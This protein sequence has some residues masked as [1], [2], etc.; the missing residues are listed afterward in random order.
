MMGLQAGN[1]PIITNLGLSTS[2]SCL[3]LSF[4]VHTSSKL[5]LQP[6]RCLALL[7]LCLWNQPRLLSEVSFSRDILPILSD[8]CFQCHG[9]DQANR[10]GNLRLDQFESAVEGGKGVGVIVPG[11]PARSLLVERIHALDA[12][13][14]MPPPEINKPLCL[15]KKQ[16]L[17]K[18]IHQGAPWGQHWSFVP[19]KRP[20]LDATQGHPIDVFIDQKLREKGMS[21]SPS[22]SDS[23]Q[24]RRLSLDL[25]GLP[26]S[27]ALLESFKD[28]SIPD[29]WERQVERLLESPHYDVV[30]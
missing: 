8:H 23:T 20:N 29:A 2:A 22:A 7:V 12:E 1:Q 24:L 5:Q 19:P 17:E 26:P 9:P 21:R 4:P 27:E 10:K 16:L 6:V 3:N 13:S 28:R 25:T 14:L 11:D 30:A 15:D 18:W